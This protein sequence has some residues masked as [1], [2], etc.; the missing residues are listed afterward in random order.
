MTEPSDDDVIFCHPPFEPE[1]LLI[2]RRIKMALGEV[3]PGSIRRWEEICRQK[4]DPKKT[5]LYWLR[6]AQLYRGARPTA[7]RGQP[8]LTRLLREA[9]LTGIL[10]CSESGPG[11][12]PYNKTRRPDVFAAAEMGERA[13]LTSP[14]E[15]EKEELL[16]ASIV[17]DGSL[18]LSD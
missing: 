18:D 11:N 2:L 12:L 7:I 10:A 4:P 14:S 13:F 1:V 5:I 17:L 8:Q 9:T 6:M 3:L 16:Q 15:A